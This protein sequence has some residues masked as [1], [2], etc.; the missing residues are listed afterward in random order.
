[1]TE[2][3]S[4]CGGFDSVEAAVRSGADAVYLGA[5]DFNARRGA[6]N[7]SLEEFKAAAKYCKINGVKV[8]VTLN[9][10][11]KNGEMQK[12]VETAKELAICGADAFIVQDLGLASALKAALPE[13]PLHA[14][15]QMAIH[16]AEGLETLK[17]L[18]FC[19]V[20]AAR[21][22]DKKSLERLCR[23]A[24]ELDIEVEVFVHGALCMCLSGACLISSQIGGRSGNRGMCAQPCRLPFSAGIGSGYDLSLKDLSLISYLGEL[25]DMGITSFKIEGRMKRPEYV[26]VATA[27]ARQSL[28]FGFVPE[29]IKNM[30]SSVFSR[31]GFTDGY[32]KNKPSSDMFGR[33][34]EENIAESSAV[35]KEIH[36]LYRT[37]RRHIPVSL[38]FTAKANENMTLEMS[39]DKN[40]VTVS[41][42]IPEIA[43]NTPTSK[44]FIVQ[45]LEKLGGS[46]Y[47]A[48]KTDCEIGE[49]LRIGGSSLGDMRNKAVE[50]LNQKRSEIPE[51]KFG[52]YSSTKPTEK[53]GLST[54]FIA[55]F[56]SAEQIPDNSAG[57]SAMILPVE[58]DFE[59]LPNFKVPIYAELPRTILG[60]EEKIYNLLLAAKPYISGAVCSNLC[61][62]ELCKKA[63]V[64][65]ISDIFMNILNKD[66]AEVIKSLG[67]SVYSISAECPAEDIRKMP[68][69]SMHFAYGL[70]PLMI[71]RNCPNRKG[72]CGACKGISKGKDRLGNEFYIACRNG[73]SE[74]YNNLPHCTFDRL[75][76]LKTDYALLYFTFEEQEE[77]Q[78]VISS[79]LEGKKIEGG[80]TRGLYWREVL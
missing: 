46:C 74:I 26:A 45:K 42:D 49:G 76:E 58:C 22:M 12:A 14:S 7:F 54:K 21:E 44:E 23:R 6:K 75:Q 35:I 78:R 68:E 34:S 62:L 2:I 55:R 65:F 48:E 8:Y 66:S 18:G 30:L 36:G 4:P 40:A 25:R 57:I 5:G 17:K 15:T 16:S 50:L 59:N 61:T 77:V 9:T 24:K 67:A 80:H 11:I 10:L 29:N 19:R 64:P 53:E 28:D 13:M 3:L 33:R 20:V 37:E 63:G 51:V 69:S 70:L 52:E 72:G 73:F 56:R 47:F 71:T 79:A 31:S 27:A 1:M 43:E 32:Y 60:S 41:G 38:K 39:D